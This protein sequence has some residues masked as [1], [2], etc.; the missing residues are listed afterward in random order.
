VSPVRRERRSAS[1]E[2][3]WDAADDGSAGYRGGIAAVGVGGNAG[4]GG[5]PR[6]RKEGPVAYGVHRLPQGLRLLAQERHGIV[7]D[8][9][10]CR[11]GGGA[12]FIERPGRDFESKDRC[13]EAVA[14]AVMYLT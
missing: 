13:G 3:T 7:G 5:R 6:A 9:F 10:A 4:C 12:P 1:E 8:L 2:R 11:G 14:D